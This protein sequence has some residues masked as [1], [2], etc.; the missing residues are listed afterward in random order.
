MLCSIA[1]RLQFLIP[2]RQSLSA[3]RDRAFSMQERFRSSSAKRPVFAAELAALGSTRVLV[4]EASDQVGADIGW[5]RREIERLDPSPDIILPPLAISPDHHQTGVTY[6]DPAAACVEAGV[7]MS[8]KIRSWK[9]LRSLIR[10][11][12][13]RPGATRVELRTTR[14]VALKRSNVPVF[15]DNEIVAQARQGGGDALFQMLSLPL[16]AAHSSVGHALMESLPVAFEQ[17][18]TRVAKSRGMATAFAQ[19]E[20]LQEQPERWRDVL[21]TGC[22]GLAFDPSA[23]VDRSRYATANPDLMLR[24]LRGEEIDEIDHVYNEAVIEGR[25]IPLRRFRVVSINRAPNA[26]G[27]ASRVAA[28]GRLPRMGAKADVSANLRLMHHEIWHGRLAAALQAACRAGDRLMAMAMLAR[29]GAGAM[30][31]DMFDDKS[32][33]AMTRPEINL[34]FDLALPPADPAQAEPAIVARLL[35]SNPASAGLRCIDYTIAS[36]DYELAKDR[37]NGLRKKLTIPVTEMLPRLHAMADW[38]KFVAAARKTPFR[39]M[40]ARAICFSV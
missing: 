18:K 37:L 17:F 3:R 14:H 22:A 11:V 16:I 29:L 20:Q 38:P 31:V 34:L 40:T 6:H 32:A 26:F 15:D 27:L 30:L 23:S 1:L 10:G 5:L 7:V 28:S 9:G 21:A 12:V 36:G 13:Q 33:R 35:R 2:L 19:F 24:L 4:L 8:G 39:P 25:F